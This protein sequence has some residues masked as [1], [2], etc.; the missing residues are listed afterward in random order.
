M[1]KPAYLSTTKDEINKLAMEGSYEYLN[2]AN[3]SYYNTVDELYKD[4]WNAIQKV[5]VDENGNILGYFSASVNQAQK[6]ITGTLFVKFKYKYNTYALANIDSESEEDVS[7][8]MVLETDKLLNISREDFYQFIDE[9]MCH[10]IYNRVEFRAIADNPAN[11]T[12]EKFMK[13][14]GG[15]RFL[16]ED[17]LILRDGKYHDVNTY[18]FNRRKS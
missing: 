17:S 3:Y 7:K 16:F 4:E 1:L 12:Y 10:P 6:K 2:F 15:T 14:Y 11:R 13:E 5:S 18:W 9:L 8:L